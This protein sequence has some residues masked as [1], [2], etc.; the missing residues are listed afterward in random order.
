MNSRLMCGPAP[1]RKAEET[2]RPSGCAATAAENRNW[3]FTVGVPGVWSTETGPRGPA[4]SPG[5]ADAAALGGTHPHPGLGTA[6]SLHSTEGQWISL[7]GLHIWDFSKSSL[8]WDVN[9]LSTVPATKEKGAWYDQGL[10][11]VILGCPRPPHPRG[12]VWT[13]LQRTSTDSS[14]LRLFP[15]WR[16]FSRGQDSRTPVPWVGASLG[17]GCRPGSQGPRRAERM[18]RAGLT[19][20]VFSSRSG[21]GDIPGRRNYGAGYLHPGPHHLL[22]AGGSLHLHHQVGSPRAS[23]GAAIPA[24]TRVPRGQ[25]LHLSE[26]PHLHL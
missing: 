4:P 6:S 22:A 24:S 5:G 3:V 11:T 23:W 14:R 18:R 21:S 13:Q 2:W 16:W 12:W 17:G 25:A 8:E 10:R 9:Q 15:P 1:L 7:P 20:C 19:G 26:P